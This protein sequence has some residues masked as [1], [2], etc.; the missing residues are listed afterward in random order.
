MIIVKPS[1]LINV[2]LNIVTDPSFFSNLQDYLPILIS[3][4]PNSN[5]L[6]ALPI[7]NVTSKVP[8]FDLFFNDQIIKNAA[9]LSFFDNGL[10]N[11]FHINPI[12]IHKELNTF[13]YSNLT[14][15]IDSEALKTTLALDMNV[16]LPFDQQSTGVT[17]YAI[18]ETNSNAKFQEK[19]YRLSV[20]PFVPAIFVT[21]LK[22]NNLGQPLFLNTFEISVSNDSPVSIK[23]TFEGT[24]KTYVDNKMYVSDYSKNK[25]PFRVSKIYDC[26]LAINLPS[27]NQIGFTTNLYSSSKSYIIS[28]KNINILGMSLK[29]TNNIEVH[30]TASD[31]VN[32]KVSDGAKFLS[33]GKRNVSGDISFLATSD[34]S[35]IFYS[36]D[37]DGKNI[38]LTMYFGS[39]FYYPLSNVLL[40]QF[41]VH[42]RGDGV[43][44]EHTI[45]FIAIIKPT[46]KTNYYEQNEFDIDFS[47]LQKPIDGKLKIISQKTPSSSSSSK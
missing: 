11:S 18:P 5:T 27:Q 38:P 46:N 45:S 33:M 21:D 42:V 37:K 4:N 26:F 36:S 13:N 14:S 47:L 16:L 20:F 17:T 3:K 22:L 29:I 8:T 7:N 23:S 9:N 31:G 6:T 1:S 43:T 25:N 32:K 19:I 15:T 35:L 28:G 30:F 24:T 34:L 39:I 2:G 44:Y 41:D 40:Q 10:V 12:K